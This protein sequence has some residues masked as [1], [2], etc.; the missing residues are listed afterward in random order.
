MIVDTILIFYGCV[1]AILLIAQ[2]F[3][4]NRLER[5][6]ISL[7]IRFAMVLRRNPGIDAPSDEEVARTMDLNYKG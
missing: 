6:Q 3:R 7:A 1:M 2:Q 5:E 4:L